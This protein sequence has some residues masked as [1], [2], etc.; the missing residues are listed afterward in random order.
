MARPIRVEYEGAVY[1]VTARGNDRRAIYRDDG[2]RE[3][4]LETVGQCVEQFGVVVHAYCLMPKHYHLLI[5][6]PRGNLSRSLGWLQTTYS[7]RFNQRHSRS[8]HLFQGRYKAIVIEAD[9]YAKELIRYIHLNPVHPRNKRQPISTERRKDL[10]R[11]RWSSHLA[12]SGKR[13]PLEWLSLDWLSY[14]G[15]R[16]KQAQQVYRKDMSGFFGEVVHNP[17]S[18]L[19]EG[20]ALT[21]DQLWDDV[22]RLMG[23]KKGQEEFRW[24]QHKRER[25]VRLKV[26][27]CVESIED[28]RIKIWARLRLAAERAVD[29]GKEFGY[30]DGSGVLRVAQRLEHRSRED[31]KLARQ[32]SRIRRKVKLANIKS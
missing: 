27:E 20:I 1:H 15:N 22:R 13:K 19:R 9:E 10:A 31:G 18:D 17:M 21:G 28:Q 4:F 12:Y 30:Q 11:Y 25:A 8:G 29:L 7:I 16:R 23:Q 24:K 6:T 2:D 26:N 5:E 3:R 32:L 14:W